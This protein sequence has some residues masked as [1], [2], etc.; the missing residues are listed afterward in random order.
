[1]SDIEV[2][3]VDSIE[4]IDEEATVDGT[5]VPS[6]VDAPEYVLYGGKGGV[7]KTTCAA[8]TALASAN[9][10]TPTLIVSTDP[11][12]SLSDILQ[13]PIPNEPARISEE[14]P[15]YGVEIDP[16]ANDGQNGATLDGLFDGLNGQGFGFGMGMGMDG[17][18]DDTGPIDREPVDS[19]P[20]FPGADETAAVQLLLEY[21]DDPR[22]DRVVV[23]TAP[24]GHTLRL[25]ALPDLMDSMVGRFLSLR[26][27]M[28]GALGSFPGPFGDSN[29]SDGMDQLE[30]FSD[31]I[32]HLRSVLQDPDRTEFRVVMTPQQ[33]SVIESQRLLDR[34]EEFGIAT[35]TVVVNRVTENVERLSDI[36]TS[37][38]VTPNVDDCT[39]CQHRWE[40]QQEALQRAQSVFRGREIKRVPLFAS[41]IRGPSMLRLVAACLD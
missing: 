11:A 17:T 8:A 41:E 24:T 4:T 19:G 36:D 40:S 3:A 33:L 25:L 39:F 13:L 38:V 18:P 15:L 7:G 22:F 6:G 1:M 2:E 34:L 5:T 16:E 28:R 20:M 21:F 31:R 35:G 12:H 23:D 37:D 9:G 10:G 14:H 26:E 27:R 29:A 30:A 32:E